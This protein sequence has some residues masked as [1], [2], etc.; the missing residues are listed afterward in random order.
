[1]K[2]ISEDEYEIL[3]RQK[4]EIPREAKVTAF[5]E[6]NNLANQTLNSENLPDDIKLQ[7]YSS[8]LKY[9]TDNFETV[10]PS[11]NTLPEKN[12]Y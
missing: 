8:F 7:L 11:S 1:M 12:N 4:S 6:T 2:L 9:L 5:V 3:K 10:V